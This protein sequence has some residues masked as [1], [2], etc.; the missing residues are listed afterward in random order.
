MMWWWEGDLVVTVVS[1][2]GGGGDGGGDE[3]CCCGVC[4]CVLHTGAPRWA[5]SV[6]GKDRSNTIDDPLAKARA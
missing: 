3:R 4:V 6:S 1:V 2:M 5:C